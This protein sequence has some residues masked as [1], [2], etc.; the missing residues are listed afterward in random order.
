MHVIDEELEVIKEQVK[1]FNDEKFS[2]KRVADKVKGF[3]AGL[4]KPDRAPNARQ[5]RVGVNMT[6]LARKRIPLHPLKA[7][8]W[9]QAVKDEC[10]A[11]GIQLNGLNDHGKIKSLLKKWLQENG[12]DDKSFKPRTSHF[13]TYFDDEE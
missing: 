4:L 11:R 9:R 5:R 13:D 3:V 12:E 6:S 7:A 8:Q 1:A 2:V 10:T